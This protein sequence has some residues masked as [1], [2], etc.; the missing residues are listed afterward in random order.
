M[1]KTPQTKPKTQSKPPAKPAPKSKVVLPKRQSKPTQNGRAKGRPVKDYVPEKLQKVIPEVKG[2]TDTKPTKQDRRITKLNNIARTLTPVSLSPDGNV[3]YSGHKFRLNGLNQAKFDYIIA[4]I[5]CGRKLVDILDSVG[6]DRSTYLLW[7]QKGENGISPYFHIIAA[8]KETEA[9]YETNL[10][11]AIT[12]GGTKAV[13]YVE[14]VEE[15][16][17]DRDGK[18]VSHKIKSQKKIKFPQWQAAAWLQER[19]NPNWQIK[20]EFG[21]GADEQ[22][23]LDDVAAMDGL[24]APAPE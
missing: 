11:A 17:R 7:R 1:K 13:E 16:V 12:E 14:S 18:V 20:E 23:G 2:L 24:S 19:R 5:R 9:E 15:I 6:I 4:G 22:A 8:I 3:N 21:A 10:L